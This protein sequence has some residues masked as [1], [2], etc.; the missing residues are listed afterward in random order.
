MTEYLQTFFDAANL[1]PSQFH[2]VKAYTAGGYLL[3][4]YEMFEVPAEPAGHPTDPGYITTALQHIGT[5]VKQHI[6]RVYANGVD[7]IDELEPVKLIRLPGQPTPASVSYLLMWTG[8][9]YPVK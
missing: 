1:T 4:L 5:S 3:T 7:H 6:E 8:Y 2:Q 9:L